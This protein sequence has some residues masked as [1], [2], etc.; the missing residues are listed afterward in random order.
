M[1]RNRVAGAKA[2][3][4]G[5][6]RFGYDFK[7]ARREQPLGPW[8]R[9]YT[10]RLSTPRPRYA[11]GRIRGSRVHKVHPAGDASGAGAVTRK[12]PNEVFE[13]RRASVAR[14][15]AFEP[16]FPDPQL[17][18]RRRLAI[19]DAIVD[20]FDGADGDFQFPFVATASN[21][22]S[23][24]LTEL[25]GEQAEYGPTALTFQSLA[26]DAQDE[27]PQLQRGLSTIVHADD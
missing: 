4:I 5:Q 14:P 21:P 1:K 26:V 19:D 3:L 16:A 7:E 25:L 8:P 23:D 15:L 11:N 20:E 18:R 17:F 2:E 13:V 9:Q 12:P 6:I 10:R 27:V 24:V 22:E